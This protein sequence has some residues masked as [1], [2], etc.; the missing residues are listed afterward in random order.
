MRLQHPAAAVLDRRLTLDPDIRAVTAEELAGEEAWFVGGTIRDELL[1]RPTGDVDVVLTGDARRAARAVA[2]RLGAPMFPLSE[3]FGTWRVTGDGWNVDISPLHGTSIEDDLAIRDL[4]LN[5]IAQPVAG[6]ALIDPH[7][8]AADIERRVLRMIS[9]DAFDSDPLRTL[10]V[11]RLSAEL[12]FAVDEQTA[13]VCGTYAAELH[14]VAAERV[15][16]ELSR[17][18]ASPRARHGIEQLDEFGLLVAV[19][20]EMAALKG[21][22][23]NRYHHLDAFQHTLL[24]LDHAI[25]LGD[26]VAAVVPDL[27]TADAQA[28]DSWLQMTLAD[29][30]DRSHALRWGAL[31]HDVAKPLTQARSDDGTVLGFPDHA[32]RGAE[33]AHDIMRR[34]RSSER[35]AEHVG[36]LA[37]MHLGLGFLVHA[38]P[39]DDRAIYRYLK[40]CDPLHIDVSL[41][42]IA[43]R[44]ATGGHKAEVSIERHMA[45]AM[46]VL[47]RA[48]E[49]SDYAK[50]QALVR[51]DELARALGIEKGPR[52]GELLAAID[53]ARYAGEVSDAAAAIDLART[54]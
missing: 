39:L 24:V 6:G 34:L 11:V 48:L 31:L 16:A 33:L 41:L 36:G 18:V 45:V 22:E 32:A 23:Q 30:V 10:R 28:I 12:D 15:F 21:L 51:G 13:A 35:L 4:A 47:P 9:A 49:W 38:D 29:G 14:R 40:A 7:G 2:K 52:L 1:G 54:L 27:E 50:Q 44:L 43:D 37:R 19:L 8:G 17:I 3:E 20:P 25:E 26:G 46:R 5:A 42:S 53:E